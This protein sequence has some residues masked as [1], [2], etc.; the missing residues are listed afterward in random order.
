MFEKTC[1]RLQFPAESISVLKAALETI[2]ADT[3]SRTSLEAAGDRFVNF[4]SGDPAELLA[5]I[6]QQTSIPFATVTMVCLVQAVP[7]LQALYEEKNVDTAIMWSTLIDLTCKVKENFEVDGIWGTEAVSW[8]S[9]LFSLRILKLGRLEYEPI[10]YKWDT[11]YGNVAKDCPVLNIHIPSCGSLPMESV[12]ESLKQAYAFFGGKDGE[13][14]PFVC[15]SWMLYPPMCEQV[16][17][18]ESNLYRFYRCFQIAEQYADPANKNFW[19]IFGMQYAPDVLEKAPADTTLRRDLL[20][21]MRQGND[22]GVG[23]G[24]FLFDGEEILHIMTQ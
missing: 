23:R 8:Y 21:W 20:N 9:R 19:R 24:A 1:A 22:M 6:A 2:Q 13:N 7:K 18:K 10:N 5:S 3:A 4:G 14:L 17:S 15:A 12:V 11:A 16:L